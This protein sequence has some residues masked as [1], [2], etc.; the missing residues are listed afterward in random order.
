MSLLKWLLAPIQALS[1]ALA[2]RIA[3][4]L[5]FTPPRTPVSPTLRA[6]LASGD[7]FLVPVDEVGH[8][9][10]WRWGKSGGPVIYLVHGWG[11]RGGRLGAFAQPLIDRGYDVVTF[12]AP[13]HGDTGSGMTS[14]LHIARALRA[15]VRQEGAAHAVIAHSLGCAATALAATWGLP[16]DR[17]V[18]LAPPADPGEW[19]KRFAQALGLSD[20]VMARL[21]ERSERRIRFRWA[22]LDVRVMARRLAHP[23][24]VVHDRDDDTVPFGDGQ[25][26]TAA[27]GGTAVR[28]VTTQGLGHRGVTRAPE[29]V[30]EVTAFAAA[31]VA[32]RVASAA[33]ETRLE[34]ELF[35][36]ELR[37]ARL[38]TGS[39]PTARA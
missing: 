28:L 4:R 10:A 12:D 15:V 7:R 13:G 9:V 6:F 5:F 1:P 31:G 22:D 14:M 21:K 16:V 11:G 23:L 33:E 20:H 3:D 25:A 32:P 29:I 8:V 39:A 34:R 35:H 37:W 38:G 30:R 2:A 27:W 24:L 19:S 26:I 17:L 18:F 36:R